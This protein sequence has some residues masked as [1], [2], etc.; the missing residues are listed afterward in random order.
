MTYTARF[1]VNSGAWGGIEETITITGPPGELE[2]AESLA[3]LSGD[4]S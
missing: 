3:A 1:R 4:Y 2:I